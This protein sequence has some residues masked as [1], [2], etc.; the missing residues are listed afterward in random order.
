MF[1][2]TLGICSFS[3][4]LPELLMWSALGRLQEYLRFNVLSP[5]DEVT[6]TFYTV[7]VYN[8][9]KFSQHPLEEEPIIIFIFK[10][11]N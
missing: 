6:S 9:V 11:F 1:H 10:T 3:E 7:N 5:R 2:F 4:H 8:T